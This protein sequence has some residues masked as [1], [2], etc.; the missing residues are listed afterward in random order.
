MGDGDDGGND[1]D[2]NGDNGDDSNS[3]GDDTS[4]IVRQLV[5]FYVFP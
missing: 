5:R 1:G 3:C 4:V 2:Y